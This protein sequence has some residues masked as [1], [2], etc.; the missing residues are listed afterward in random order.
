MA[1]IDPTAEPQIDDTLPDG[2]PRATLKIIRV[3]FDAD[4]DDESDED[5]DPDV[6]D[7]EARLG[8]DDS[9]EDD[10][11]DEANGGPGEKTKQARTAAL[12]EALK[13]EAAE[14]DSDME[15]V[16]LTNGINGKVKK[17]KAKASDEEDSE[18]DSESGDDE[19][20]GV[21]EFVICTLDSNQ[22][23][24]SLQIF[25]SLLLTSLPAL[26]ADP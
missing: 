4:S 7:I 23:S 19:D 24:F 20:L 16:D 15:D 13:K 11:D 22:V 2:P 5:N 3:P 1:A 18:E 10:S 26:S 8:L 25:P 14:E 21:E 6:D 17:G 9:E 12:L